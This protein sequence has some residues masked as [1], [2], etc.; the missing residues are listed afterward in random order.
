MIAMVEPRFEL[1]KTPR[2]LC[3]HYTRTYRKRC[4]LEAK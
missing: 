1:I 2:S 3:N 4:N